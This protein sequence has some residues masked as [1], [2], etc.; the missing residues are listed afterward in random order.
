MDVT[1][2]KTF[3]TSSG[4]RFFY[5]VNLKRY[6]FQ[7]K[8]SFS[9]MACIV[10][11]NTITF[12]TE[13]SI[14]SPKRVNVDTSLIWVVVFRTLTASDST[15]SSSHSVVPH[16]PLSL[17]T[18]DFQTVH[19]KFSYQNFTLLQ[20]VQMQLIL[21]DKNQTKSKVTSHISPALIEFTKLLQQR[22]R[23]NETLFFFLSLEGSVCF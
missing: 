19:Y 4:S 8:L 11:Y 9:N 23:P 6:F 7:M 18:S 14:I 13:A 2:I 15:Q 22:F 10:N 3:V 5:S 16:Q 12:S 17:P 1:K 20:L 21:I